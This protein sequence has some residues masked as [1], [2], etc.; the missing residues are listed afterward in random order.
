MK[1][2]SPFKV[3]EYRDRLARAGKLRLFRKTYTSKYPCIV[4]DN[5]GRFWDE[6]HKVEG[7]SQIKSPMVLDRLSTVESWLRGISGKALDVGFGYGHIEQRLQD[8]STVEF[9]G[10]DVSVFSVRNA[11]K[12]FRGS[13][14]RGNILDIRFPK[15][16]FDILICLEVLEHIP[17]VKTFKALNECRRV[18]KRGGAFIVSVPMNEGLE[19]MLAEGKNSNGHC[20][21]YTKDILFSELKCSGFKVVDYKL[22]YAFRSSYH[23]KTAIVNLF[24]FPKR[25]P[26]NLVVLAVKEF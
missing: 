14:K 20:R 7:E 13:F 19:Q 11:K 24:K 3:E 10:I 23:L 4:A 6:K 17:T 1:F 12:R 8:L 21:S 5:S 25:N 9:F 26:N 2:K 16:H 22:L 18:L 15:D